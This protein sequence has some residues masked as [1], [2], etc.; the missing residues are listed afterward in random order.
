[1]GYFDFDLEIGQSSEGK[2][3]VTARSPAGEAQVK[4]RFPFDEQTLEK[5]LLK[6]QIALL[7]SSDVRRKV[8]S[9]E[10]QLVEEFGRK[11]FDGILAGEVRIRYDACR[12][13]AQQETGSSGV[14]LRLSIQAPELATLPWEFL[15]DSRQ[16]EYVCLSRSTPL[17]RYLPLAQPAQPLAIK[18]P[19]RILC[20]IASPTDQDQLDVAREQQ[21]IK[22]ALEP[23]ERQGLVQ[24][25]WIPG[26]TWNDLQQAM[27]RGPW[28]IFHFIG[29]GGFHP[30]L[31]EGVLALANEQGKAQLLSATQLTRLLADHKHLRLA[32]LN[33]CDGAR[34][35]E[36]DIFSSTAATL[37]RGGVPAVLAMQYEISDRAAIQLTRTFYS[38][39][40]NGL[41]VDEAVSEVR[42]AISLD[43][44]KTLEWATPVLFMHSP[45]GLLFNVAG[46]PTA[47]GPAPAA[48]APGPTVRGEKSKEDWLQEGD[49]HARARR[50]QEA[51]A[52]YDAAL[53]LDPTYARA[54]LGKGDTLRLLNQHDEALSA[55]DRAIE[56]DP[57]LAAAYRRKAYI[58]NQRQRHAEA[59]TALNNAIQLEPNYASAYVAKGDAL[60][61]L[62]RYVEALT[63][64]DEA[65]RLDAR[66]A[67]AYVGKGDA[68]RELVHYHEALAAYE[69]ALKL[70][71]NH[72]RAQY[73]KSLAQQR[74]AGPPP[75]APN[76][77]GSSPQPGTQFQPATH[78]APGPVPQPATPGSQHAPGSMP[79]SPLVPPPPPIVYGG[80][81]GGQAV[82]VA[83]PRAGTPRS[84]RKLP[85]IIGGIVV[86]VLL[87]CG[88]IGLLYQTINHGTGTIPVLHSTY[89]GSFTDVNGTS[90]PLRL[91]NLKENTQTGA[92]TANGQ[93]GIG[94][95]CAS[96]TTNGKADSSGN[97]S[98]TLNQIA[99]ASISC[100]PFT[101]DFS[102]QITS[103]GSLS[104]NFTGSAS[105]TFLLH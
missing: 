35:G 20:M 61:E 40:A 34:G 60:K 101:W 81:P 78:A 84:N 65:I 64:Y 12:Q 31:Q 93:E 43:A 49:A 74:L 72:A 47:R 29:H 8:L 24:L 105:G 46:R 5:T 98:F 90:L 82:Q 88:A 26:Q 62:K 89:S 33:A 67:D 44:A 30:T 45:D 10:Q 87:L 80:S 3:I 76:A 66:L 28:H 73:G 39:L 16:N 25:H 6:M 75:V 53:R 22:S 37:A 69:Q 56:L 38:A 17:V 97:V 9:P 83:P 103:D 86:G 15:Y 54:Y 92:F 27:W 58:L 4:V 7:Q 52:A 95:S 96:T 11:L 18:P 57:R 32:L 79:Q 50:F 68:Q 14:R 70:D 77:P 85:L 104:G 71:P 55:L 100:A 42:K 41:P 1:M 59:L 19:L 94:A 21:R 63:A 102:G 2:Y 48:A 13:M 23:L 36:K 99:N 51:L 91:T